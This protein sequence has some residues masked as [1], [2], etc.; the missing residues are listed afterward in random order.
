[1]KD[2]QEYDELIANLFD[3]E[4]DEPHRPLELAYDEPPAS[5]GRAVQAATVG[6][7]AGVDEARLPTIPAMLIAAFL[8]GIYV[9]REGIIET[10]HRLHRMLGQ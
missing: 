8:V 10:F 1:M 9:A 7:E 3:D 2:Q 5:R 6:Y 4:E